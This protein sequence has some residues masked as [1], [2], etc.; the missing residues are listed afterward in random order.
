MA[1]R[2][3]LWIAETLKKLMEKKDVEKVHVSD[4]CAAAEIER[5]TFYYHFRDKYDLIAWIFA[6]EADDT[7]ILDADSAAKSM[8]KMRSDYLF[9][10]RA[11]EDTSQ[12]PL[13]SYMLEYFVDRYSQIA[14]EKLK[15][16]NLDEETSYAIRFYCYGSVGMTRE[17]L[18][19]QCSLSA[20]EVVKSMYKAMPEELKKIFF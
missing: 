1:E 9:Y 10:K 19:S 18:L 13:W 14:K 2:T 4:I 5:A 16:K 6:H 20:K 15:V 11:Y 8:E 3:K 12:T 17:W 7:D